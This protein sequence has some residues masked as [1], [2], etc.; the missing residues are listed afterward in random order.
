MS[1][2]KCQHYEITDIVQFNPT[3]CVFRHRCIF[4]KMDYFLKNWHLDDCGLWAVE[5]SA[6]SSV[7]DEFSEISWITEHLKVRHFSSFWQ[8]GHLRIQTQH[9][10]AKKIYIANMSGIKYLLHVF[11]KLFFIFTILL[12]KK[13]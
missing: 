6:E 7:E 5:Q 11:K 9:I 12:M 2:I 3:C 13:F 1:P 8:F 4:L 10:S